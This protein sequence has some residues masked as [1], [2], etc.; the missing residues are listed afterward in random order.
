MPNKNLV[1]DEDGSW[2]S[3]TT[4]LPSEKAQAKKVVKAS[5]FLE[6]PTKSTKKPADSASK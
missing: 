4:A 2:K 1:R 5:D 6:K 3:T